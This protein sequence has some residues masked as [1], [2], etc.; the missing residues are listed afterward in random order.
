MNFLDAKLTQHSLKWQWIH[1]LIFPLF[2]WILSNT[3]TSSTMPDHWF[4]RVMNENW[5][6]NKDLRWRGGQKRGESG[7]RWGRI[8]RRKGWLT[9]AHKSP[10]PKFKRTSTSPPGLP[11]RRECRPFFHKTQRGNV[12]FTEE[13]AS[14]ASSPGPQRGSF[15]QRFLLC[16]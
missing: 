6:I 12:K 4:T 7:M 11:L 15:S 8:R 1:V 3:E 13:L 5:G 2:H 9:S 10:S 14:L 16:S